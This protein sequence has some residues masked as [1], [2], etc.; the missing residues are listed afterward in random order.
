MV[1]PVIDGKPTVE[2]YDGPVAQEVRQVRGK[3]AELQ[4][5]HFCLNIWPLQHTHVYACGSSSKSHACMLADFRS[6]N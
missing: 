5:S 6:K 4:Q 2:V 1:D 3:D